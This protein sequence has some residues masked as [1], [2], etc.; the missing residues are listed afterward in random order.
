MSVKPGD[1]APDF[2][3]PTDGN[4][5]VTLVQAEGQEGHSVFLSEGRHLGLHGG[6]LRLSRQPAEIRQD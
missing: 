2:T 6:G 1:K 4:G 3:L 5:K